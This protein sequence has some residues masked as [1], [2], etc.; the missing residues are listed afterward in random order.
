MNFY[1]FENQGRVKFIIEIEHPEQLLQA[2]I[3][4][5]EERM[6]FFYYAGNPLNT[7]QVLHLFSHKIVKEF[8]SAIA[9][10]H[11]DL[12]D[13]KTTKLNLG[14]KNVSVCILDLQ[15]NIKFIYWTI[16]GNVNPPL[17][18]CNVL[19]K[20]LMRIKVA[21]CSWLIFDS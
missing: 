11:Q 21:S 15:R 4:S 19:D 18:R 2:I 7:G 10:T 3:F 12:H 20:M 1:I 8:H 5:C 9:S 17:K 14:I 13:W 16:N 6:G